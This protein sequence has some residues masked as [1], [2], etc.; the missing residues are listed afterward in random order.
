MTFSLAEQLDR[1]DEREVIAR[2][3]EVDATSCRS[4]RP[5]MLERFEAIAM[6]TSPSSSSASS[7]SSRE[8]DARHR[9][10]QRRVGL[11]V[12]EHHHLR[13]PH[14]V[15][16]LFGGVTRYRRARRTRCS[17]GRLPTR[18]GA[19]IRRVRAVSNGRSVLNV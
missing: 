13:P 14:D 2:A 18:L 1:A 4:R 3:A 5:V 10:R 7:S 12:D 9:E 8:T 16:G 15:V 6:P 19:D 17:P 11:P